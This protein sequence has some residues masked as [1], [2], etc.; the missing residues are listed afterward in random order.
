MTSPLGNKFPLDALLTWFNREK[1]EFP[2]RRSPSFYEVLVSEMML[3]QTLARV[4]VPYYLAWMD[5]FPS[6]MHLADAQIDEVIKAWEGLGYYSRARRLYGIAQ[7][8][9]HTPLL[10]SCY[11]GL[12]RLE[13]VGDY[14]ARA[15]LAFA[16]QKPEV[17]LDGN[18]LR[19]GARLLAFQGRIDLPKSKKKIQDFFDSVPKTDG[20]MAESLIELGALICKKKPECFRCPIQSFC[21]SFAQGLTD[22]IPVVAKRQKVERLSTQIAVCC[23]QQA[24]LV[25]KQTRAL[26][27]DLYEFPSLAQLPVLE[28]KKEALPLIKRHFTRFCETLSPFLMHVDEKIAIEGGLWVDYKKLED[29]PFSSGHRTIK[30][31]LLKQVEL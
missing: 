8:L 4:V 29:L 10:P 19:V 24:C 20:Q 15:I 2:W 13:G 12:K 22:K 16:Y 18:V 11:E 26:M 17:A 31:S 14:T 28:C 23:H 6:L 7:T 9:K 21:Q 25:I 3:Q 27:Q 30:E 1:R 5:R